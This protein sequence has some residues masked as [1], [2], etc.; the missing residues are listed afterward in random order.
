MKSVFSI[1]VQGNLD[2]YLGCDIKFNE[3]RSEVWIGQ[4]SIIDGM[5]KRF[6]NILPTKMYRSPST[7]GWLS[8]RP[9]EHDNLLSEGD[10]KTF[11]GGVGMLLH[12]VKHSRPDIANATRELS[13]IMDGATEGQFKELKRLIKFVIDTK[14]K[15]LKVKPDKITEEVW[16]IRGFSDS[17][18]CADKETRRS[19][20]GYVVY[21]L[22]VAISWKSKGQ[23]GVTLSTTEAEYV[24][25]SEVVRE[26]KFIVQI[27]ES[28][29]LP[30][31]YPITVHVDN[32]GAI[33]LANNKTTSERTKHVDIRHHFVREYIEDGVVKVIFVKSSE[34]DADLFTKNLPGEVYE[35]HSRKFM[36]EKK[37][38]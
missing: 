30:I 7:P 23:R 29:S 27:L 13:K 20:T 18:Y 25:M 38:D 4:P 5:V 2:D 10:Q 36:E 35:K 24:A 11:R 33:F 16:T 21:L 12:L 17:D 9:K 8:V 32:I 31:D 1:K 15:G 3:D 26:I 34:N 19:I 22:G 37:S 28:M 6:G 14:W